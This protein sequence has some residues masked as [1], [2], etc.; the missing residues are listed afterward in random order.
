[1]NKSISTKISLFSFFLSLT[2][3]TQAKPLP[4]FSYSDTIL[5]KVFIL[6]EYEKEYEQLNIDYEMLLL[7]ACGEDMD[8]AFSKWL[9]MLREMEAYATKINFELKGIKLW[10]NIF[11][12]EDGSIS[13]IAFHLKRNSRNT[14]IDELKAFLS[15]FMNHYK[16]PLVIDK[17]YSHY[18][19]AAFPTIP[20]P[21]KRK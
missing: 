10:M 2:L 17:K 18:G 4:L 16:F 12:N 8:V 1:M 6:G 20:V 19:S 14:N 3:L 11:W 5:P 7:T 13:H 15:S 9:S 21:L